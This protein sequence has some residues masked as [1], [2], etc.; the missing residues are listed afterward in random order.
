MAVLLQK[1]PATGCASTFQAPN[2]TPVAKHFR[3]AKPLF[4]KVSLLA[5]GNRRPTLRP[6][7]RLSFG[8]LTPKEN[9]SIPE[10]FDLIEHGSLNSR[11]VFP[12]TGFITNPPHSASC[13]RSNAG[14]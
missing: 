11:W 13:L 5:Q 6:M 10:L 3:S 9:R 12:D 4:E 1:Y 14:S 7:L 2:A 8:A